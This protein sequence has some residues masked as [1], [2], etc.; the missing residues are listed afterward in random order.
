[1]T[2][3][4]IM[5]HEQ[6]K[7]VFNDTYNS[8]YLKWKDIKTEEEIVPMW[9]EAKALNRKNGDSKLCRDILLFLCNNIELELKQREGAG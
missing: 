1:M 6:I 5:S 3:K 7:N 8:F 2:D 9:E 4:I